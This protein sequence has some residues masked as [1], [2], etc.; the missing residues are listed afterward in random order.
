LMWLN[1][2]P[3][4]AFWARSPATGALVSAAR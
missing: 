1:N 4:M 3:N 2:V